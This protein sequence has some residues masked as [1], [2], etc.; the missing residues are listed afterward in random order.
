[1]SATPIPY[2][3]LLDPSPSRAPDA[4]QP[5]S[6]ALLIRGPSHLTTSGSRLCGAAC[7]TMLRIARRALH[8]VRDTILF[9]SALDVS[10]PGLL[11]QLDHQIRHRNVVEFLGHLVALGECPFEELDGLGGRRL[12]NRLLVHQDEGR[13]GDWPR[14]LTRLV[15]QDHVI[16]GS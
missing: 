4:A 10:R 5:T 13:C 2:T 7:R 1:M 9:R 8:R 16:A 6:G 11:D 15:G 12:I 14:S 3:V